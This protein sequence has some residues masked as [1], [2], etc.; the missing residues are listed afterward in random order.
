MQIDIHQ[1]IWTDPLLDALAARRT[2]P[3]VRRSN[4]LTV[5][6]SAGEQPYMID[7]E[8]ESPHHRVSLVDGDGLDLAVVALSSAIGVE[9]LPREEADELIDAHLE[10]VLALPSWFAAW[11]PIALDDQDPDDVDRLLARD[12]I[13]VCLPAGALAGPGA[14]ALSAPLLERI[15]ARGA[16]LFVHPGPAP[17]LRAAEASLS[18]PLCGRSLTD[19]VAQMQAAWLTFA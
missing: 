1:H 17:G 15:E 13:G 5:L 12:C 11:G 2:L 10:G 9:A 19:Y 4:G 6:H 7:R 16:P 18:E 3:F 14:L 8:A